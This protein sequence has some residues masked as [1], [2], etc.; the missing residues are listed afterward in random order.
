MVEKNINLLDGT[1][2]MPALMPI[3][4]M[5]S[6]ALQ[7]TSEQKASFRDWRKKNYVNMVNVMNEIIEQRI[8]FK[9]AALDTTTTNHSLVEMQNQILALQ[10]KLLAIKLSC[11]QLLVEKFTDEQ[12][13][14]FAFIVSDNP[15]LAVFFN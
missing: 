8:I 15:K 4:M 13:D 1:N 3:I 11:R 7:L 12:W 9:K 6:D 10:Q 14:N 2:F 5:N